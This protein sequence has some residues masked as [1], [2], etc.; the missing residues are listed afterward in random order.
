[1]KDWKV[2]KSEDKKPITSCLF[3]RSNTKL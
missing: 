2:F 3:A 1:M